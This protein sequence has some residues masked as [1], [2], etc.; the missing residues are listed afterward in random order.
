MKNSQ[1]AESLGD[2]T[3]YKCPSPHPKQLW[4]VLEHNVLNSIKTGWKNAKPPGLSIMY[5]QISSSSKLMVKCQR[6]AFCD[7]AV[8]VWQR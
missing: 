6:P 5:L 2:H 8:N 1:T 3:C 4:H 7:L